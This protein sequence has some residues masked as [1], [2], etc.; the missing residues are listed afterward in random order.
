MSIDPAAARE[1]LKAVQEAVLARKVA[2]A[3]AL[4]QS[5]LDEGLRHPVAFNAI[6]LHLEQEGRAAEAE[7]VLLRGLQETPADPGLRNALGLC[8]MQLERPAEALVQ[9]DSLLCHEAQM[10]FIHASRGAALFDLGRLR[11]AETAYRRALELDPRQAV[12]LAGLAN[13]TSTR[14]AYPAARSFAQAA[15]EV[16]PG[17]PDAIL[18]LAR[19]ELG[20]HK[21]EAAQARLNSLLTTAPAEQ[22]RAHALGLLGDVL[23]AQNRPSEAF[24]AYLACNQLQQRLYAGRFAGQTSALEYA[25][26]MLSGLE[27]NLPAWRTRMSREPRPAQAGRHVF[28]LGF[29]R[30]GT[31]LLEV[32][33]EG[34]PDVASIEERELLIDGVR[35]F[36]QRPQ[37]LSGLLTA[38][39]A[40]LEA[41]RASYWRLAAQAHE[42]EGGGSLAGKLFIDKHP[43]NT[44]K[45]PLI[46]LLFPGA[47]IL[48][49]CRDPRDV[50]L[51]CFRHRFRMSAPI[52]ELLTLRGAAD[53]FDAVMRVTVSVTGNLPL[54]ICL[55]RHEDV[56]T[57]FA[58][59]MKRIC[60]FLGIGWNPAMG[61]FGVRTRNR[62]TVTPSTA[63]LAKGL[64]TEG[65]GQW[66]RYRTHLEP[67]LPVLAPWIERFGYEPR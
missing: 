42:E 13:L 66:R 51:S 14:G 44:L 5:A 38:P 47:K 7:T 1:R 63:Q 52:Y 32:I 3:A 62:A 9:F 37:D 54:D 24:D 16:L 22:V 50:V 29:P 39:P 27:R 57:G 15:L 49:A 18:S 4:A 53:Y 48:F 25:Q 34:H 12:A 56:V 33:L 23:D 21:S 40:A 46:A 10:P 28:L 65:V 2:A 6:A 64:S 20:E 26:G 17:Y 60:E 35:H 19:A 61:D 41:L 59:E 30:S 8:L 43:L 36:M 67:V 31:T 58:R 45:L 55:V 11:D